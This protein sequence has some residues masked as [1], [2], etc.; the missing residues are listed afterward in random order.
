MPTSSLGIGVS[1]RDRSSSPVP[2]QTPSPAPHLLPRRRADTAA[3]PTSSRVEPNLI[4]TAALSPPWAGPYRT[5]AP[6][7]LGDRRF[8][9]SAPDLARTR[10]RAPFPLRRAPAMVRPGKPGQ[11][12]CAHPSSPPRGRG[13]C[14]ASARPSRWCWPP[15][16][17]GAQPRRR[18]PPGS[19]PSASPRPSAARACHSGL[20]CPWSGLVHARRGPGRGHPRAHIHEAVGRL[21]P[22]RPPDRRDG[23]DPP[24]GPARG[25]D[26]RRHRRRDAGRGAAALRPQ[27]RPFRARGARPRPP[28]GRGLRPRAPANPAWAG[29]RR[30]RLGLASPS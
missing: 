9:C 4:G 11:A 21:R 8:F 22:R 1:R 24:P 27:P 7:S 12:R 17:R 2:P 14:R 20:A 10:G 3:R 30:P 25:D 29:P 5:A 6:S 23:P 15:R 28:H 18:P 13:A 16:R 19:S 26:P